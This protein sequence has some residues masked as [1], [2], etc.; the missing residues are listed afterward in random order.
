M[1]KKK[2][3]ALVLLA[4]GTNCDLETEYAQYSR[5]KESA[6]TELAIKVVFDNEIVHGDRE[7]PATRQMEVTIVKQ[8]RQ[9]YLFINATYIE[10]YW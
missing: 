7:M 1:V 2:P 9:F 5:I 3:K 6:Y 4:A 8:Q 10:H